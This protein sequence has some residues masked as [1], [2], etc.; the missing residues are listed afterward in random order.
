[1]SGRA[2]SDGPNAL[3]LDRLQP[4][5]LTLRDIHQLVRGTPKESDE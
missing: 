3:P 2:P 1:M 4:L 5:L